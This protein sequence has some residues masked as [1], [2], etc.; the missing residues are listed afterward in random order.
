MD[1]CTQELLGLLTRM[2]LIKFGVLL[3]LFKDASPTTHFRP[4]KDSF[5]VELHTYMEELLLIC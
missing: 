5:A 1:C 2:S 3:H 4:N